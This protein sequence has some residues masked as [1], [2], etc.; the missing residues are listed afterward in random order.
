MGSSG[1]DRGTR[2]AHRERLLP[3]ESKALTAA[4]AAE[5]AQR[6]AATAAAPA[7]S[8]PPAKGA[9]AGEAGEHAPQHHTRTEHARGRR[10]G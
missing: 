5:Q 4:K 7:K 9:T 2:I 6:A 3:D 1:P 10:H 8:T